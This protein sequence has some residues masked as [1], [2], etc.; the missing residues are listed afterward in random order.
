M[1]KLFLAI[2]HAF[3]Q[4]GPETPTGITLVYASRE[5]A[6]KAKLSLKT[7]ERYYS[8]SDLDMSASVTYVAGFRVKFAYEQTITG[9]V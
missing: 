7:D 9:E 1:V 8:S 2:R 3:L 4:W 5:K 6:E